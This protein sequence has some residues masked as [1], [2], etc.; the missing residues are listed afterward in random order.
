M[1]HNSPTI[2]THMKQQHSPIAQPQNQKHQLPHFHKNIH[3]KTKMH[4]LSFFQPHPNIKTDSRCSTSEEEYATTHT[5]QFR[6]PSPPLQHLR[7]LTIAMPSTSIGK[8]AQTQTQQ[9]RLPVSTAC[10]PLATTHLTWETGTL[11]ITL[12]CHWNPPQKYLIHDFVETQFQLSLPTQTQFSASSRPVTLPPHANW[13]E[14]IFV[15]H[16][17]T[18]ALAH[19]AETTHYFKSDQ[20]ICLWTQPLGS[21]EHV[22]IASLFSLFPNP[23]VRI[24]KCCVV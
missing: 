14:S 8:S 9:L 21:H 19:A 20:K 10:G 18:C 7:L 1:S 15:S 3:A 5:T 24:M 17:Q 6:C 2:T 22:Q 23:R 4:L 13:P 16:M 12:H 11:S